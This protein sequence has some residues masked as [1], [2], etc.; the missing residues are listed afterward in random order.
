MISIDGCRWSSG[1][2][3]SLTIIALVV[4]FVG[5]VFVSIGAWFTIL[6]TGRYPRR[7]FG[8]VVGLLRWASRVSGYA[9]TLVTDRYP[10]FS[11][12]P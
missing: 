12:Q 4:L 10:P 6:F 11:L 1:S 7:T 2:S 3:R 9:F 5:V 8:Y